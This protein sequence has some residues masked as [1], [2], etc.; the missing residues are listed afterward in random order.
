MSKCHVGFGRRNL[1]EK[2]HFED[3]DLESY[4]PSNS[5]LLVFGGNGVITKQR[6]TR[7]C[8][9]A[10]RF[11]GL[12]LGTENSSFSD[13]DVLGFYYD[14]NPRQPT[15][16]EF[17]KEQR[18]TIA[19]NVFVKLC[20]D[21]EGRLLTVEKVMKKFSKINVLS[22]CWGALEISHISVAAERKMRTLGYK[23]SEIRQIFNQVFHL[24][25]APYTDHSSF[26]MLRINSFIDSEFRHI[27]GEYSEAYKKDLKGVDI[28]YDEVGYFRGKV[29]PMLKVPILS[30]YSSQLINTEDNSKVQELTDEHG[31]E[32]LE[33]GNDWLQGYQSKDAKNANL[34]SKLASISL[35]EA[36]AISIRNNLTDELI[37]KMDLKELNEMLQ[38][39]ISD[40]TE[41]ELN[42]SI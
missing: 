15:I 20:Y 37:P 21:N 39:F 10:E 24:S 25:Y 23:E 2:E 18:E 13:V 28:Q 27:K 8:G 35:A 7:I 42:P 1:S 6:A 22:H 31:R 32:I 36:M 5:V 19:E 34:V 33:R 9:T 29:A 38:T 14:A 30:I 41:E 4:V 11:V 12:K 40:Y 26:P 16:G 3:L 17:S